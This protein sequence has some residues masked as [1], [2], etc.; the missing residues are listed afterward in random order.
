MAIFDHVISGAYKGVIFIILIEKAR[1]GLARSGL[2]RPGLVQPDMTK[3]LV[4]AQDHRQW[5]QLDE[6]HFSM[7]DM[8]VGLIF[9]S[10]IVFRSFTT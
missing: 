3:W 6:N 8:C 1:S 2:A 4:Q 5:M 9:T 10:I 7:N